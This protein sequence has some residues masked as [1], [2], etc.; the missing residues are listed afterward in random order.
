[1]IWLLDQ[2]GDSY[3]GTRTPLDCHSSESASS[4]G[5]HRRAMRAPAWRCGNLG[6]AKY[7][8]LSGTRCDQDRRARVSATVVHLGRLGTI[9]GRTVSIRKGLRERPPAICRGRRSC[10]S[11]HDQKAS[12]YD[13][14]ANRNVG[15]SCRSDRR[16]PR[17]DSPSVL[18]NANLSARKSLGA[19][20]S[21]PPP[22][23]NSQLVCELN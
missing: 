1:M 20:P 13:C 14:R 19:G 10:C 4:V 18:S 2:T 16:K 8:H 15:Q 11:R 17:D 22:H 23:H 3:A 21:G 12:A 6:H 9:G 7:E 5:D